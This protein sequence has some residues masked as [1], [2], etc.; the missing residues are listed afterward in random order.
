M[1]TIPCNDAQELLLS[2]LSLLDQQSDGTITLDKLLFNDFV[3][4]V[5][6]ERNARIFWL[7]AKSSS[8]IVQHIIDVV[9]TN[10][11]YLGLT[12]P[13]SFQCH[14]NVPSN[15]QVAITRLVAARIQSWRLSIVPT[16]HNLIGIMW[17]NLH[18]PVKGRIVLMLNYYEG[19]YQI[20]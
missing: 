19:V 17:R 15:D 16:S 11:L 4:H 20:L 1:A 8:S 14:W 3:W 9:T 13:I 10:V 2:V 7:T 6:A 5:W 12:L 18:Y